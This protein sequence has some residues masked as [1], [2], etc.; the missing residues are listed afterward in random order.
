[1]EDYDFDVARVELLEQSEKFTDAAELHLSEGHII[2]A[3]ELF[4]RDE[5]NP[6]SSR[7]RAEH[8]LL[9]GLWRQL[10]FGITPKTSDAT[11]LGDLLKMSTRFIK[12]EYQSS[13]HVLDQASNESSIK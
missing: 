10:S 2:K 5:E 3:I 11:L 8:C 13:S 1:M 7:R 12:N 4:L 9:E 6:E